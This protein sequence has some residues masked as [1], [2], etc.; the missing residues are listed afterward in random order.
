[1]CASLDGNEGGQVMAEGQWEGR[2][3]ELTGRTLPK[4]SGG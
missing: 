2:P 3:T 1:M 4:E